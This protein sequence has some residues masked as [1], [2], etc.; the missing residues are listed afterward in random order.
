MGSLTELAAAPETAPPTTGGRA[1]EDPASP[2]T[3]ARV[4]ATGALVIL[5]AA[6]AAMR[7]QGLTSLGLF[8]DDA[9]AAMSSRVGLGTAT[10]MWVTAPGFYF[11]ERSFIGLH[12]HVTWWAQLPPLVAGVAAIPAIYLLAR[13]F[14]LHRVVG[15]VLALVVCV[16]PICIVYS[17]RVK[18]HGTAFLVTCAMLWVAETARRRPDRACVRVLAAASVLAFFVSA[19]LGP[20]I[21]GVW[22]AFG[23]SALGE[24]SRR[25]A[26]LAGGAIV[27]GG[28]T[29]VAAIFY[30]HISPSL[31]KFWSGNYIT[32]GS[33]GAFVSTGRSTLWGV[34]ANLLHLTAATTAEGTVLLVVLLGFSLLG[35]WRNAAMLGPACIIVVAV[36]A[37]ATRVA[38]LGTGRTD[39]YLYPALLLLLASGA[40][41][42]GVAARGRLRLRPGPVAGPAVAVVSLLVAAVLIG[43]ALAT[44]PPYPGVGMQALAADIQ[45]NAEPTDHIVVGELARYSWAYSLDRPVRVRFG[46]AW[47][48]NFTVTSTD[49]KVFIVPSEYY[50]GDSHPER[51]ASAL[52]GD[53]RLWFVEA[54]PLS[55]N[56]TYAALLRDGWH[57]VRTLQAPGCAAILLER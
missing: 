5:L 4:L 53:Q 54:P 43:A 48:T 22:I 25:R 36:C 57:P 26:V 27:A 6:G 8:R 44:V 34:Y 2:D 49:P 29:V 10:H 23:I 52:R 7:V 11:L 18:E 31:T 39:E 38:P 19:S 15:L 30:G 21:A 20:V 55:V 24:P 32:H 28:C 13:F 47:S 17:T 51:W 40:V 35:A 37:S 56:P 50:E 12:P 3:R 46:A 16:S 41:R 9:W 1:R 42:L 45:R 33:P 14:G